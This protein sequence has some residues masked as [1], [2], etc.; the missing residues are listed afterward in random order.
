VARNVRDFN[1][2]ASPSYQVKHASWNGI[3]V[4]VFYRDLPP[5]ALARYAVAALKDFSENIGPY[6]Y[7]QL[8]VAEIPAGTGME[9]P[10]LAWISSSVDPGDL[11]HLVTH[12]V[13]HQWFYAAVGNNQATQPFLDEAM[14]DFLTGDML[15]SFRSSVCPKSALDGSVYDYSAGCYPEVIYVQGSRYLEHFKT[16]VGTDEF[17]TGVRQFYT[18]Y[19]FKIAGTRSLLDYLDAATGYD[20]QLHADRF[21]SLY[22]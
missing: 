7:K 21:P 9:S 13:A 16:Q 18:D 19:A 15:D 1:F 11:Q 4:N 5:R 6:P 22:R 2:S 8:N 12:E 14:A 10:A 17:W 3:D 20:S